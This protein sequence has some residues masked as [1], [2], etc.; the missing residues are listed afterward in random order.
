MIEV[1]IHGRGGQGSVVASKLLAVAAF[2][3][4]RYVQSFPAFGVERRGAPLAAFVR[5]A[6]EPIRLRTYIYEPHH[7]IVLD[8]TLMENPEVTAGLK[9]GGW[10]L[11][12][13]PRQPEEVT[14]KVP[15]AQ[16]KRFR[17]ATV[18]A[19]KIAAAHGLGSPSYPIVNTTILGAFAQVAGVVG[20]EA[21]IRAITEEAPVKP[22][23]NAQ[24]A[25]E[26]YQQVKLDER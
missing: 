16:G 8:S 14:G 5:I 23:A 13:S 15:G 9:E 6:D 20:F 19:S 17:I 22:E 12:N 25:R 11:V 26:A 1:R 18:D 3:E 10:I 7:V 2:H 4:G 24:A 21:V